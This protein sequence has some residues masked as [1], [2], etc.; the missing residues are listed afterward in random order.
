MTRDEL[1]A[2]V[3][4]RQTVTGSA[5]VVLADLPEPW[6]GQFEQ[7]LQG[8]AA[9]ALPDEGPCAWLTDWQQ[10]VMGDW[11][12]DSHAEGLQP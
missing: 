1:M 10:W 11:H 5:Y 2:A 12:R 6:R 4:V 8:S 9:P 7:A 3:P